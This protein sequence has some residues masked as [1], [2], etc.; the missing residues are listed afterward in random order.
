MTTTVTARPAMSDAAG[1]LPQRFVLALFM[2]ALF[3]G[4]FLIFW[5][6]LLIAKM[7]L[8][9][10]GGSPAVWITS[11]VFFQAALLAGYLYAHLISTRLRRNRQ[12]VVHMVAI[13]LATTFLPIA[14]ESGWT[15]NESGSPAL[16][17]L[18]ILSV[19]IGMPFVVVSAT[20]PLLQRWFSGTSHPH[21]ADPYFLYAASNVGSIAGLLAFPL[22]FEPLTTLKTQSLVWT[23]GFAGLVCLVVA[24]GLLNRNG[25]SPNG[26]VAESPP[27]EHTS[28][29][30]RG[31]WLA[32]AAVPSSLLLGVTN[33]ITTDIAAAP[34]L[35]VIPLI[36][37][38]L[39]FVIVFA[40]RPIVPH[41]WAVRLL[42]LG[43]IIVAGQMAFQTAMDRV[44]HL[45]VGLPVHLLVFFCLC[46]ACHGE[47]IRRRPPVRELT[48]FYIF[49]SLGG[50]LGGAGTALLA[51]LV[52]DGVYEY[53]L[54]LIATCLLMPS[55]FRSLRFADIILAVSIIGLFMLWR[56]LSILVDVTHPT[57]NA[58]LLLLALLPIMARARPIGLGLC[59]AALFVAPALAPRDA[60]TI[61]RD[62][63]FFGVHRVTETADG[64]YRLLYH[65]T[66]LHGAQHL[67]PPRVLTPATYYAPNSPIARLIE[68]VRSRAQLDSV[69]LV[70]LGAGSLAC[71]HRPGEDWTYFE[72]DPLVA[73]IASTPE[74]FSFMEDCGADIPVILGDGR[75]AL[76]REENAAFDFLVIDAFSSD[77]IPIHL[78]TREAVATYFDKLAPD[79]VL[80]LHISNR[81]LALRP[82]VSRI[83]TELDLAGKVAVKPPLEEDR[84]ASMASQWVILARREETIERLALDKTWEPLA[85]GDGGRVWTDDYSNILE[86]IKWWR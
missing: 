21:A 63:G 86:T 24:C 41:R 71:Y 60:D 8:P 68:K 34:M 2:L 44:I 7:L 77:A 79:G 15:P 4:A 40:R 49:L 18:G 16:W 55:R 54:A 72:I 53:P 45:S 82:V 47:L 76:A 66:T 84:F 30:V 5:I 12:L 73:K 85:D 51:P 32:Y 59:I 81:N 48:E 43:V 37:Y 69:G 10:L 62:R 35:W 36:L 11:M 6:Q 56:E 75:L 78:L 9:F 61:W 70:G 3:S 74:L 20:A 80:A 29:R 64:R 46:L 17:L 13:L 65:G 42:P 26:D 52:F 23:G 25:S 19:S 33:H 31:A 39:S 67:D 28:W 14:V 1:L 27:V 58:V 83:K 57:R 22:L 50:V 38:L